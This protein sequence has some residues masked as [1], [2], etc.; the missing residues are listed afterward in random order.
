MVAYVFIYYLK[1]RSIFY[2]KQKRMAHPLSK[3]KGDI[4][5]V[6]LFFNF[7]YQNTLLV[8]IKGRKLIFN[9]IIILFSL[10]KKILQKIKTKYDQPSKITTPI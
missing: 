2:Q 3:H 9:Q 4:C 1:N 7:I 8:L 10:L 6:P 5:N